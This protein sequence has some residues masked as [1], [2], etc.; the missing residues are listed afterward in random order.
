VQS[1]A[2]IV[3]FVGGGR[4]GRFM[5]AVIAETTHSNT[6][7]VAADAVVSAAKVLVGWLQR[8]SP[9]ADDVATIDRIAALEQL[10]AAAAGAQLVEID[11]LAVGREPAETAAQ[12]GL[13]TKVSAATASRRVVLARALADDLP[14]TLELLRDG[15]VSAWVATL[16]A[17]ETST[18][19]GDDRRSADTRL[20][21][22][23]PD[24]GPRQVEAAASPGRD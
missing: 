19:S 15:Q 21:P 22:R 5:A 7:T 11:R 14:E 23:L 2:L 24:L 12:V 9:A 13:A 6:N 20:A 3:G 16:V 18:L 10:Q 4:Y 1:G 8:V 17:R